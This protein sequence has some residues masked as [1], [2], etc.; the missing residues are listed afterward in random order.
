M[1]FLIKSEKALVYPIS[2]TTPHTF[3]VYS[4]PRPVYCDECRGFLWGVA[5]QGMRCSEC[6]VICH[7]KC[8]DLINAD[9][10][11]RAAERTSKKDALVEQTQR[12]I[13]VMNNI[14]KTRIDSNPEVFEILRQTFQISEEDHKRALNGARQ[15]ILDGTSQ[16]RAKL[17]ITVHSAQ[18]LQAKDK[19]GFS[20]PYVTVQ[21]GNLRKRTKTIHR[22]LN[23]EWNEK[24]QFE[25]AN[26][27]DR[28]KVR[29]WDEDNDIKSKV[30]ARILRESDDFLGQ[31]VIEVRTLSGDNEL[32]YN[33]EKRSEKSVVSGAI[34]LSI[35]C[36]IKGEEK[37]APYHVQYTA[38]HENLFLFTCA[39]S[40]G[41]NTSSGVPQLPPLT[42]ENETDFF[43][44]FNEQE[45]EIV[46]E[47]GIRYGI[48]SIYGA[49]THFRIVRTIY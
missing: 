17:S 4:A 39:E 15:S 11:Q 7:E 12:I 23:P 20:D 35:N 25:C 5:R 37:L 28:I 21:I 40:D 14:M 41:E 36:E 44:F 10:L 6:R 38:L 16:W 31:C 13:T 48:E 1:L 18:G 30:K 49:M 34:K 19:T 9:C 26:S 2:N 33:L 32:W 46:S 43:Q 47:F 42:R 29:V 22:E 27:T 8:K 3:E 24:F 45:H